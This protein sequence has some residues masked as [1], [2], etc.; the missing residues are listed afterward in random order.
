M[1][2]TPGISPILLERELFKFACLP[3]G[4]TSFYQNHEASGG[5]VTSRRVI[6]YLDDLSI[7][8]ESPTLARTH[9]N[10]AL[11]LFGV[12]GFSVNYEKSVLVPITSIEFL[13][14]SVSSI[15][16]TLSLPRDKVKRRS[17]ARQSYPY[18]SGPFQTSR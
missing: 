6:V 5:I 2:R 13:G 9:L 4:S 10:L 11:N 7:M 12:L 18:Y 16:L 17:T 3:F 8:A 1:G 15:N 14:F